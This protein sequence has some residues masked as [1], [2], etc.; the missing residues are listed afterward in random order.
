MKDEQILAYEFYFSE[1]EK[2]VNHLNLTYG[3]NNNLYQKKIGIFHVFRSL[4]KN[5]KFLNVT[6][7]ESP[8]TVFATLSRMIIDQYSVFFLIS[9]HSSEEIQKL[10]YYLLMISSLEGRSKTMADFEESLSNLALDISESNKKYIKHDIDTVKLFLQKIEKENLSEIVDSSHIRR[11]NWRFPCEKPAGNKNT[12]N[13]Q[14]LYKI[15]KIP[16]NFS[17]T[18]QQH[19][20]EFTHGLGLTVLYADEKSVSKLSILAVLTIIQSYIG[21]IIMNEFS[22]ELQNLEINPQFIYNCNYNWNNWK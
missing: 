7:D 4:Y 19:F 1:L 15:S 18:I 3:E 8:F 22:N 6:I 10:R 12:Y 11:R 5:L 20:S 14:E 13:W 17:K 21:K 16:D 2:I 9:S